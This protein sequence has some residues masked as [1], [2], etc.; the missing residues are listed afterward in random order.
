MKGKHERD[1]EWIT[2]VRSNPFAVIVA[3][4]IF[5]IDAWLLIANVTV[6]SNW[7]AFQR[8]FIPVFF[9]VFIFM[10]MAPKFFRKGERS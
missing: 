5:A 9:V 4:V 6:L 8:V 7:E 2:F 10:K 3:S 1:S